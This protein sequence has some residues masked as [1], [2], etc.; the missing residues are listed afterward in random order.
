MR[1][2]RTALLA[3][4]GSA[5]GIFAGNWAWQTYSEHRAQRS[6]EAVRLAQQAEMTS[7]KG[8]QREA[9]RKEL[10][11]PASAEFRNERPSVRFPSAWCGEV[12]ARNRMGG[13]VGFTRYVV[14]LKPETA[15]EGHD[16]AFLEKRAVDSTNGTESGSDKFFE[17]ACSAAVPASASG[18]R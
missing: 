8:R 6:Q 12:N 9:V 7:P 4:L 1:I 18:T 14:E 5:V 11:D 17:E 3:L 10:N 2:S 13:M 16:I 15:K